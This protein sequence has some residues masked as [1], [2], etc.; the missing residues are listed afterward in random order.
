MGM[1]LQEFLHGM[2]MGALGRGLRLTVAVVAMAA[3]A[4]FYN[5]AAFKNLATQEGMDAAQLAR[6]IAEGKGYTTQFVRP[7]SIHFVRQ[8]VEKKLERLYEGLSVEN[9]RLFTGWVE[10][11]KKGE[12]NPPPAQ[13]A[14]FLQAREELNKVAF[15]AA[16][17]PDLANAPVYPVLL[18]GLLK[19]MPF[20][21]EIGG[22]RFTVYKPD[23][24]IAMF[25]QALLLAAVLQVFF[26]AR[27]WF[28]PGVAWVSAGLMLTAELLWR[29]TVSGQS[30]VLLLVIFLGLASVLA[31]LEHG[32]RE[33]Q[34]SLGWQV[35][36]AVLAGVLVGVGALTRYSFGWLILPVLVFLGSYLGQKKALLATLAAGAF[37]IVVTP[38]LARNYAVSGTPLGTAGFAIC[39]NTAAYPANQLERTLQPEF[40]RVE[41]FQYV[42]KL[43]N[44]VRE[45]VRNDLPKLGGSWVTAFFLVG[46]L[47][48]F[49]NP[50]LGRLRGFV[51][52]SL[53]TLA[54]AQAMGRT[55]LTADA[56]E[57]SSE[58]LL[59]LALPLVLVYGVALFFVLL[60][61]FQFPHVA[62]RYSVIGCFGAAASLPLVLVFL[63]PGSSSRVGD[64]AYWPPVV[65][66]TA[67]WMKEDELMMSDIPWGVS[68]YGRRQCAW[69]TLDADKE[70]Y[71]VHDTIKPIGALY[72]T[73]RTLKALDG[74]ALS[75]VMQEDLR[76]W[77]A[78]TG[79]L[80]LKREVPTGFPLRKALAELLP[81]QLFLSDKARWGSSEK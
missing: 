35:R 75:R 34:G 36:M 40:T 25:N 2:E 31:R 47:V 51:L 68:W 81:E 17:H 7:L 6:N 78:F 58:N 20:D 73:A 59:A 16:P 24:W 64:P 12:T 77:D 1:K 72:L 56:T 53:I 74:A 37:L 23:L 43:L 76:S 27:R 9:Q 3:M 26:L 48:P 71:S 21:Y 39:Q 32:V 46:L 55:Q 70:F 38:W 18:A 8:R 14:E 80:F 11:R 54:V 4:V 10:Q 22:G 65:Q 63:S 61:Q 33:G 42:M 79:S 45:L 66:Q 30:T 19:V 62:M 15:L 52:G 49:R 29:F 69:L 50:T 13:L 41:P 60:E 57:V 67:G 5:L 44:G 28:D